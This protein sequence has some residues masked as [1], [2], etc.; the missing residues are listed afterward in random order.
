MD[1]W[2][3]K[4]VERKKERKKGRWVN[5]S[6]SVRFGLIHTYDMQYQIHIFEDGRSAQS[7]DS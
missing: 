2:I 1:R 4:L 3:S 7:V 6:R 5:S